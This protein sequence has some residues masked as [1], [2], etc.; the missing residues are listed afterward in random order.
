VCWWRGWSN[1]T[2]FDP[3]KIEETLSIRQYL[4]L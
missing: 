1:R 4:R 3:D 2:G